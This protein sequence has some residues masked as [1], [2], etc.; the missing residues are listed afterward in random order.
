MSLC[1]CVHCMYHQIL[2]SVIAIS[3]GMARKC[4]CVWGGKHCRWTQESGKVSLNVFFYLKKR[5][6]LEVHLFMNFCQTSGEFN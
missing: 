2:K 3:V 5:L 4:V 6:M 1:V